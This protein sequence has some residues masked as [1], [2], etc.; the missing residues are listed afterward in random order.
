LVPMADNS[1]I[2]QTRYTALGGSMTLEV[3]EGQGHNYNP[4]FFES[5]A[6][7]DFV[8]QNAI[9]NAG[10]DETAPSITTLAPATGSTGAPLGGQLTVTFSEFVQKGSTGNI[11]I[12][13]ASDDAVFETLPATSPQITVIG[14]D[15]TIDPAG[16]L[17]ANTA[18][19]VQ[20]DNG[21]IEDVASP[22]NAFPGI[23]DT[24]TWSFTSG[25][26]DGTAPSATS[27]TPADDDPN[28]TAKADLVIQFDEDVQ[29]GSGD[30]IITET[31]SGVFETIP[32]TDSRV[33]VKR[34]PHLQ[35]G[36]PC[37]SRRWRLQGHG[38]QS[39][40]RDF[41]NKRL[42][43]CR[44]APAHDHPGHGPEPQ[45][46]NRWIGSRLGAGLVGQQRQLPNTNQRWLAHPD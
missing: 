26:P 4:A 45:L 22:A 20:I 15:V 27:L 19:Y 10:P 29:K 11:I 43:L 16:T 39:M 21:A 44:R 31:G 12:K 14:P 13:R 38:G 35:L 36:L 8:V 9:S 32:A 7:A 6:M 40:V 18:Y 1:S 3:L 25:P 46:R 23:S 17:A 33:T 24:T 5:Q 28:A 42:E 30:I 2:V 34:E 41:G 37:G